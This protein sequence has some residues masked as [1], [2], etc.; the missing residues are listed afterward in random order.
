MFFLITF[1]FVLSSCPWGVHRMPQIKY[2]RLH[3]IEIIRHHGVPHFIIRVIP[4][5]KL[6]AQQLQCYLLEAVEFFVENSGCVISMC[7]TIVQQPVN[8]PSHV[9]K[10]FL[11]YEYVQTTEPQ[12][13]LL[14]IVRDSL[15][16]A[17]TSESMY[18]DRVTA[19]LLQLQCGNFQKLLGM[20]DD[21]ASRRN[22]PGVRQCT[23]QILLIANEN[24]ATEATLSSEF[25]K[26]L[27][28]GGLTQ[29]TL[30]MLSLF[31]ALSYYAIPSVQT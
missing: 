6:N 30:S 2:Q 23:S 31:N 12:Q 19:L 13:E 27:D 24:E 11:V 28:H 8:L 14:K 22:R 26:E 20:C 17:V 7:A 4:V 18:K 25:L 29:P 16:T 15:H 10:I 3:L 1:F 21:I 9:T 5:T